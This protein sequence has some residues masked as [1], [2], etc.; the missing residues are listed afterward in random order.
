MSAG[1]TWVSLG[2]VEHTC[3]L[4]NDGA[5]EREGAHVGAEWI[6]HECGRHWCLGKETRTC[7]RPIREI[8][9]PGL[10]TAE[11]WAWE[12]L[13]RTDWNW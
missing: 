3:P 5:I 10:G 1:G 7:Y 8:A 6:C 11:F 12:E 13:D 9:G 2:Q 4:P